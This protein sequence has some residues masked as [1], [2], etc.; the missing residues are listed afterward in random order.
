MEKCLPYIG[1]LKTVTKLL[2][3]D[4]NFNLKMYILNIK[5]TKM[6]VVMYLVKIHVSSYFNFPQS[7]F[8]F[9]N[10]QIFS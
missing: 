5:D 1:K 8:K 9:F 6:L 2:L 4:S 7:F 10:F 3:C